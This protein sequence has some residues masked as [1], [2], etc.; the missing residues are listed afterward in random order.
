MECFARVDPWWERNHDSKPTCEC[1]PVNQ[2]FGRLAA[3]SIFAECQPMGFGSGVISMG[4]K[5]GLSVPRGW[6]VAEYHI[7]WCGD[8]LPVGCVLV[9]GW[10][11]GHGQRRNRW[12]HQHG[13]VD[14]SRCAGFQLTL[15]FLLGSRCESLLSGWLNGVS[16][17]RFLEYFCTAILFLAKI[18]LLLPLSYFHE[19]QVKGKYFF[20]E[21]LLARLPHLKC[22]RLATVRSSHLPI[23][24]R[25]VTCVQVSLYKCMSGQ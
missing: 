21:C 14:A 20:R 22:I 1:V 6:N 9:A 17:Q 19:V 18:Y 11:G 3:V 16:N 13:N 23:C 15:F 12:W 10:E 25:L 8:S 7:L 24:I 5:Y 2:Y 4:I